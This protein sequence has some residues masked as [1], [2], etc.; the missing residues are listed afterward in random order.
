MGGVSRRD[1]VRVG[2]G[3]AAGALGTALLNLGH[4]GA[5]TAPATA[6]A[7]SASYGHGVEPPAGLGPGA[8]DSALLPPPAHVGRAAAPVSADLRIAEQPV[9]GARGTTG[10]A[11]T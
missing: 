5:P 1:F 7:K 10:A 2:A 8:L 6:V 4:R 11:R 9:A 3:V